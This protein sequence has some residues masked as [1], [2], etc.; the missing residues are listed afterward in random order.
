MDKKNISLEKGRKSINNLINNYNK[1]SFIKLNNERGT[2]NFNDL[3]GFRK[4][5]FNNRN[6]PKLK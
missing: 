1:K 3:L 4:F 6:L 5:I 2:M